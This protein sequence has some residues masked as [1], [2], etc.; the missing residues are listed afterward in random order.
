MK[1]KIILQ[2]KITILVTKFENIQHE[3]DI[4][5]GKHNENIFK[6]I[7]HFHAFH[8]VF[9][10]AIRQMDELQNNG[11]CDKLEHQSASKTSD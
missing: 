7:I 10:V 2:K 11:P 4:I 5:R 8:Y 1:Q 9:P 3:N 6:P